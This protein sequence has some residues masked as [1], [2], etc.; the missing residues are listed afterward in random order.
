[1]RTEVTAAAGPGR[2]DKAFQWFLA[3]DEKSFKALNE[4][5]EF[6]SLGTK[7][8]AALRKAQ[9]GELGSQL[10]MKEQAMA[11][12][13]KRLKGRQMLKMVYEYHKL[14]ESQNAI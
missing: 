8:A 1:M 6:E 10:T 3:F 5:D 13:G 7:L 2:S 4:T 12:Y 11:K 14:D 9:R